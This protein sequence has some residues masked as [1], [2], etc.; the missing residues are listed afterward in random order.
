MRF[1]RDRPIAEHRAGDARRPDRAV[2]D[3]SAAP[4]RAQ[5]HTHSDAQAEQIAASMVAF[6]VSITSGCACVK[7]PSPLIGGSW[8]GSPR[9]RMGLKAICSRGRHSDHPHPHPAAAP[10]RP[11]ADHDTRGVS[12]A[13]AEAEPRRDAGQGARS[14]APLATEDRERAGEVDQRP[15]GAG[16]ASRT[17]MYAGSCRSP[18]WRPTLWKRSWTCG[19]GSGLRRCWATGRSPGWRLQVALRSVCSRT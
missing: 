16:G 2:A 10:R 12:G 4:V 6:S 14:R 9:T 8:P 19:R 3:R 7:A 17:P 1:A 18:V 15:C 5:P 11:E 13:D